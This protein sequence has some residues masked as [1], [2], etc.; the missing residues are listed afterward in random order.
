MM[1]GLLANVTSAL[2]ALHTVLGCCWHHAH[3][4][5]EGCA[6]ESVALSDSC[7]PDL[8]HGDN[9]APNHGHHGRHDCRGNA[10]VFL[11]QT[12]TNSHKSALEFALPPAMF[13]PYA[14]PSACDIVGAQFCFASDALLPPL[15]LH[16]VCRVLLI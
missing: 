1:H 3:C 10:C 14:E 2:L 11:G 15:R 8:A 7:K 16:L 4:C 9:A 5:T 6:A 13:A 12:K